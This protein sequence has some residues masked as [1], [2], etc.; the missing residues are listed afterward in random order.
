[1][2]SRDDNRLEGF[3]D[4]KP[5]ALPLGLSEGADEICSIQCQR[6]DQARRQKGVPYTFTC[7]KS[8]R[9]Q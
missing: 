3:Y 2:K 8:H 6:E 5:A 9:P 1:M 7:P 4:L